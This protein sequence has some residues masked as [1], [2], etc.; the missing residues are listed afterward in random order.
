MI[1]IA[2]LGVVLVQAMGTMH[3]RDR[4]MARR[5]GLRFLMGLSQWFVPRK[6]AFIS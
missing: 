4:A 5:L 6:V 3:I 2:A 1:T